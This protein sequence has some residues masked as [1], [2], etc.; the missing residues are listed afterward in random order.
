MPV[1][2]PE[3]IAGRVFHLDEA[4]GDAYDSFL[5]LQPDALM[6]ASAN[7]RKLLRGLLGATDRYL[8]TLNDRGQIEAALPA[9]VSRS[10]IGGPVL[11]S[12]PFYGSNGGIVGRHNHVSSKALV[13]R[14]Y[15]I[16]KECG[17]VS[18]VL[19]GSPLDPPELDAWY[20]KN[21]N[22]DAIDERIGQITPIYFR[23]HHGEALMDSFHQK[24]RN[25]IRKATKVG[26]VVNIEN[27]MLDFVYEIHAQNMHVI[28]GIPKAK[29]FFSA[30]P[31][32]FK[33]NEGFK[34]YVARI[35][36]EPVA[37]VLLFYFNRTVE[38]FTPVIRNEFRDSQ[39]L[40]GVIFQAMC[41]AS[42]AGFHW[43]N[44]GG[45]WLNQEGVYRF[46][47]R[48][49]AQDRR[50]R[51]FVKL[52]DS[53]LPQRSREDILERYPNFYVLPFN[54]LA[55]RYAPPQPVH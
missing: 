50:Y 24:T 41:D 35:G 30:V 54:M 20:R 53:S 42:R 29:Q 16:A 19:I 38:Y 28:G 6:F 3:Q 51:Y 48:W 8:Y 17:C 2:Q 43:W 27:D 14:F 26:V 47:K 32:H 1:V 52:H 37:A 49:G 10:G 18:S 12:L 25:T 55:P 34:V 44:W 22:Y 23:D 46:K 36:G 13:D 33:P 45:T 21:L 11:N 39:A 5:A 7:Y 40:S 9:F 15:E 4:N 31:E